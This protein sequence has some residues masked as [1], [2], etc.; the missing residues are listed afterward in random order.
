MAFHAHRVKKEASDG[1]GLKPQTH[2]LYLRPTGKGRAL[3]IEEDANSL[4][5]PL[6]QAPAFYCHLTHNLAAE[7]RYHYELDGYKAGCEPNAM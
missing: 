6:H 3:S 5:T 2:E 1:W 4:P 7:P